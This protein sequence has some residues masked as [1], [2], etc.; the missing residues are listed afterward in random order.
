MAKKKGGKARRPQAVPV[1]ELV[2][3]AEEQARLGHLDE[4]VK[5]LRRA[6]EEIRHARGANR[7]APLPPPLAE[8]EPALN[9]LLARTLVRRAL[10]ST[11]PERQIADLE[12]ALK[13]D[14]GYVPGLLALG[15]VRLAGGQAGPAR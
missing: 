12:Q 15:A 13:R 2:K 8:T 9:T 6:D 11:D 3:R 10:E 1:G 14:P 5:T 4:A 7:S